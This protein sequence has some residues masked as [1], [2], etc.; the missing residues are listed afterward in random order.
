MNPLIS[1]IVPV[2]QA[3]AFLE[4]CLNSLCGQTYSN[5]EI[6]LVDDGSRD[7]SGSICDA[8]AEKDPRVKVI[9]KENAGVSAARNS[10][11]DQFQGQ[12]LM[13][14]DSDDYIRPDAVEL[15]LH[16]MQTDGSDLAVAQVVKVDEQENLLTANYTW[17]R[18]CVM[19]KEEAFRHLGCAEEF[20]CY[21]C[22]KLYRREVYEGIRFPAL[23]CGEDLWLWPLVL[24]RCEKVSVL[25]D[26][27]YFYFQHSA[28]AVHTKQ[29]SKIMDSI[30]A[31]VHT[32]QILLSKG[33]EE[34]AGVYFTSAV[35]QAMEL[36]DKTHGRKLLTEAFTAVERNRLLKKD[37]RSRL[38][39]I[40]M[41]VPWLFDGVR[42]VKNLCRR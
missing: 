31:A 7:R 24:D 36:R 19:T 18:D 17:M 5:L 2:Y 6:L 8:Y 30:N 23:A 20:P 41:Y 15:M 28:S 35:H 39:W 34:N 32:A 27:L 3:E 12:Y 1:I 14:V 42:L 25:S 16:R 9:H 29:D 38:R 10:A 33:M 21:A 37:L 11:L 40:S 22:C 13:F 4:K 26:V